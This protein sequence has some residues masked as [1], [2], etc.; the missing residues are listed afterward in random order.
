L[1]FSWKCCGVK[2][3]RELLRHEIKSNL[4]PN[5]RRRRPRRRYLAYPS[6]MLCYGM[7]LY[8]M[9]WYSAVQIQQI[10]N[11]CTCMCCVREAETERNQTKPYR[12]RNKENFSLQC[13]TVVQP[14]HH[15]VMGDGECGCGW[16]CGCPCVHV[17][18]E[19]M[20]IE[21]ALVHCPRNERNAIA[22]ASQNAG[23]TNAKTL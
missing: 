10:F 2:R 4:V 19:S 9:V 16:P 6:G 15:M 18:I 21:R 11:R 20:C 7:V 23:K 5:Y 8:G 3:M 1:P 22:N 17:S 12:N 14:C 13:R